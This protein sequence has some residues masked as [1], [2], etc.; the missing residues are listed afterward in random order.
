MRFVIVFYAGAFLGALIMALLRA[1]SDGN[2][3]S[4]DEGETQS[5]RDEGA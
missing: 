2:G 5:R 4:T 3:D 1:A